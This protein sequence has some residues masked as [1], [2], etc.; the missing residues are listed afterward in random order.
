MG[1]VHWGAG[2][3]WLH[4][5][6]ER[7]SKYESTPTLAHA[8]TGAGAIAWALNTFDEARQYCEQ[9]VAI[10]RALRDQRGLAYALMFLG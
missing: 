2:R 7:A 10:W 3:A 9:S 6:L 4:F 8:L 1:E 5:V